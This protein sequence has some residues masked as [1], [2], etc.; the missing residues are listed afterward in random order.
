MRYLIINADDFGMCSS[1]NEAIFD[2]FRSGCLKS[3]TVMIPCPAA[4]EA[5]KFAA[6]NPQYAVGVH[7]T[8]TNEWKSNSK[9]I[10]IQV[11][12]L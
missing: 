5:V 8:T 1:A 3:S 2:L 7:L 11:L 6:E 12:L 9:S 10:V 4:R